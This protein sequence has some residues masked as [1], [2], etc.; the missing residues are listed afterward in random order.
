MFGFSVIRAVPGFLISGTRMYSIGNLST[1]HLPLFS[2]C[3]FA[4]NLTQHQ[5]H[6]V[7]CAASLR[8]DD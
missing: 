7:I 4:V 3:Y 8:D 6:D 1:P 2:N 5:K